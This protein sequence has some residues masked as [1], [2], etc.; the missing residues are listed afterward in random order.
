MKLAISNIAWNNND[1][2]YYR[3]MQQYG[4]TGLEIAPTKFSNNPY[5]HLAI[6]NEIQHSLLDNYQLS[7]VSM[8][9][10]LFGTDGMEL[11]ASTNVRQ[12]LLAYLKKAIIYAETIGCPVLVFGNPKNRIMSDP[13]KDYLIALEFFRE[14]GD[15]AIEHN[16]YL[17]I[18]PNPKDYGTNFINTLED[19]QRLVKDVNSNGFRMIIDTS[20]MILNKNNPNAIVGV[21]DYVKHIHISMPFLKPLNQ[22]YKNHEAWLR[23]LFAIIRRSEY[24]NYVS[25]EMLNTEQQN[26]L[27][28]LKVLI[29][30]ATE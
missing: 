10:L 30:L 25:I 2:Y 22:E 16:T 13:N 8:Q 28:S 18:E 6:A 15:F 27:L 24:N 17:C 5:D 12:S 4:F 20:T 9:S 23:D 1:D 29:K 26:V 14:L 21:L 3:I 19:A 11:F 7:V